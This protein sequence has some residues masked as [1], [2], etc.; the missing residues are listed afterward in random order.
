MA[1]AR[2]KHP[3]PRS[4]RSINR[5]LRMISDNDKKI[6]EYASRYEAQKEGSREA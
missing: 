1:R 2:K 4:K 6:K 5:L 3:K